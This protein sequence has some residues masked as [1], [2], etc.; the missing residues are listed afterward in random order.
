MLVEVFAVHSKNDKQSN[1]VSSPANVKDAGK[2]N[3]GHASTPTNVKD[4]GK[5]KLGHVS[6]K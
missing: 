4:S 2:V 6:S 1:P 3:L 5:V